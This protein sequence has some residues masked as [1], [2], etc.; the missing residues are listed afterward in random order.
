MKTEFIEKEINYDKDGNELDDKKY[1]NVHSGEV[2]EYGTW[3]Y[4]DEDGNSV[5]AV[6]RGEVVEVRWNEEEEHWEEV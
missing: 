5:N 1:M 3:D 4:T 2:G 6:D